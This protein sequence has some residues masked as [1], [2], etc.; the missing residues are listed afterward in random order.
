M[1]VHFS[2]TKVG[3]RP[4]R[5]KRAGACQCATRLLFRHPRGDSTQRRPRRCQSLATLRNAPFR[6]ITVKAFTSKKTANER[7]SEKGLAAARTFPIGQVGC[8]EVVG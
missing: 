8:Q 5:L 4:C 2:T 3:N 7:T 6:K 1:A